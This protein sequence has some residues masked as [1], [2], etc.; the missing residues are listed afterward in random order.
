M[1]AYKL[2]DGIQLGHDSNKEY[3]SVK[4][5]INSDKSD[6]FS[7]LEF[8]ESS[9]ILRMI[10]APSTIIVSKIIEDSDILDKLYI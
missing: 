7:V 3:N 10:L 9:I 1:R 5:V 2:V 8:K 4:I 6:I